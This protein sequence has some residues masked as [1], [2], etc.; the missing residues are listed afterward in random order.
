MTQNKNLNSGSNEE[1]THGSAGLTESEEP[2]HGSAGLTK[3]VPVLAYLQTPTNIFGFAAVTTLSEEKTKG[4]EL[5]ESSNGLIVTRENK[6][7]L[8]P[9]ANVKNVI[10]G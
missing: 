9:W 1:P 3:P 10:Y 4:L 8:I 7:M 2:T 6:T 5:S